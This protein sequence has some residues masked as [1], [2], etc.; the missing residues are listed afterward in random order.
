LISLLVE[1]GSNQQIIG[2]HF[3]QVDLIEAAMDLIG[4]G[5]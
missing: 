3:G 2:S 1:C 5:L 4:K